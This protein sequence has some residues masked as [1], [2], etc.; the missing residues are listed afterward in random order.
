[1]NPE[2]GP[3]PLKQYQQPPPGLPNQVI[4]HPDNPHAPYAPNDEERTMAMLIHLLGILTGFIGSLILWLV[5]KDSS[6]FIDHHGKEAINFLITAFIVS[7][8]MT[9]IVVITF[10]IGFVLY[11]PWIIM[12]LV[13]DIIA[14]VQAYKGS[15]HRIPLTIRL[16]K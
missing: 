9:F 3:P 8:P 5:K 6:R 13:F 15:W 11:F 4:V 12:I 14:C 16:I 2:D 10:G 1:M 7:I